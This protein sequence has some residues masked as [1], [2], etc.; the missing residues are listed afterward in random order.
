MALAAELD[1]RILDYLARDGC[2]EGFAAGE[3]IL[4]RGQAGRRFYLLLEGEAGVYLSGEN[5][6]RLL[7]STLT[8]GAFFG[9]MSALT[10]EPVSAD[11]VAKSSV[12]LLSYPGELLPKAMAEMEPLRDLVTRSLA[13]NVRRASSDLWNHFQRAEAMSALLNPG[14]RPGRLVAESKPMKRLSAQVEKAA[15]ESG[16]LLLFGP[17]GAGKFFLAL[18]IH[19]D[20]PRAGGR[21]LAV[22]C[23]KLKPG[24]GVGLLFGQR[25]GE[26][27]NAWEEGGASLQN[28]GA[29]HLADGGTLILR[30]LDALDDG[31]KEELQKYLRLSTEGKIAYPLT[32]II[33]TRSG[34]GGEGGNDLGPGLSEFFTCRTL[35]LPSLRERKKDLLALASLFLAETGKGQELRIGVGAEHVLLS[36]K[37]TYRNCDELREAINLAALFTHDG[38]IRPEHIFTGAKDEVN[39]LEFD[40]GTLGTVNAFLHSAK[41]LLLI[42]LGVFLFFATLITATLAAPET[43]F[44]KVMNFLVWGVW[45]PGLIFAFLVVGRVWC[46]VCPLSSTS[47]AVAGL[48]RPKRAPPEWL[49]IYSPALSAFGLLLILWYEH[50]LDAFAHPFATG[51]LLSGLMLAALLFGLLYAR[52]AWCRY[53]CP[54]GGLGAVHSPFSTLG[55][56]PNANVCG[57]L[58]KTHDC[59]N[60]SATVPGCPV[61]HHPLFSRDSHLCKLCL[62]C[63]RSCPHGSTRVYLRPPLM[64]VWRQADMG[65]SLSVFAL[66]LFLLSL[67]FLAVQAGAWRADTASLTLTML[68]LWAAAVMGA[69]LM[70]GLLL[71]DANQDAALPTRV[72]FSLLALGWGV[73]MAYQLGN[74]EV[75]KTLA[76]GPLPGT[77][78]ERQLPFGPVTLLLI[79]QLC[80]LLLA[81]ALFGIITVNIV[82]K[83]RKAAIEVRPLGLGLILAVAAAYLAAGLALV[84]RAC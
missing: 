61:F 48:V 23:R 58:C 69:R 26:G 46:T 60:G 52:E 37:Y 80:I 72:I 65:G 3:T 79:V 32:R 82:L 20:G 68:A 39:P 7:L 36:R 27:A 38:E 24:E 11:V 18:R 30:H 50:V 29:V 62:N 5:A 34:G 45:E 59:H 78:W 8:P 70:P 75:L 47:R 74:S 19:E 9:E 21:L 42:R 12:R 83:A 84:L 41:A 6:R 56:H 16:H 13:N 31:A 43:R 66:L 63:I 28:H 2:E 55:L 76:L 81:A 57:T 1:T 17:P 33:A 64:R 22:D 77:F 14:V 51:V 53:L 25:H 67:F 73:Q 71:R 44:G 54:M 40:L 49:K 4:V 10:G 15:G 35:S